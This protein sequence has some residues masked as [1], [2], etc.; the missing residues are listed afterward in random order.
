MKYT[1]SGLIAN[2]IVWIPFY[3]SQIKSIMHGLMIPP[4]ACTSVIPCYLTFLHHLKL[5]MCAGAGQ[6][7]YDYVKMIVA[8]FA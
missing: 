7:L 6:Y 1:K 8:G 5:Y 2:F 3:S 4:A